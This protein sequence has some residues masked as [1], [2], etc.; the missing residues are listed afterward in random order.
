MLNIQRQYGINCAV[1]NCIGLATDWARNIN[2]ISEV[3]EDFKNSANVNVSVISQQTEAELA[4]KSIMLK[5]KEQNIK[6]SKDD[7]IFDIL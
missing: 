6:L 7:I 2:N 3:I 4:I 1:D 5:F